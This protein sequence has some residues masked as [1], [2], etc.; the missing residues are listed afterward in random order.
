MWIV[1]MLYS[2][3]SVRL[4]CPTAFP[5]PTFD[6][7]LKLSASLKQKERLVLGSVC[8]PQEPPGLRM[9][10]LRSAGVLR[11]NNRSKARS[12][13]ARVLFGCCRSRCFPPIHFPLPR[14]S[15]NVLSLPPPRPHVHR[16]VICSSSSPF[17]TASFIALDLDHCHSHQPSASTVPAQTPLSSRHATHKTF[18]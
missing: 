15:P 12:E 8:A 18:L 1:D 6:T 7:T 16:F 11:Q 5:L 10:P 17:R 3:N 9:A 14:L 13:T 4:R 2:C